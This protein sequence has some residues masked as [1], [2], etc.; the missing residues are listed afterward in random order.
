MLSIQVV[1]RKC[2]N[3]YYIKI[4]DGF[5]KVIAKRFIATSD[6]QISEILKPFLERLE[7]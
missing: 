4:Y 6:E 2:Q 5:W 1:I 3:G 7:V